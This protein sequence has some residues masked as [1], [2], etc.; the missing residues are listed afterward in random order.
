MKKKSFVIN[1]CITLVI[2]I[3]ATVVGWIFKKVGFTEPN[4]VII[5]IL[6]V[7]FTAR[8]T[9]GYVYGLGASVISILGFNYFFTAPYHTFNVYD[10]S[11]FVTFAIMAIT[12]VVTSTLTSKAKMYTQK[13]EEK[14]AQSRALYTLTNQLS[15]AE[16]TSKIME[17]G[18]RNICSLIQADAGFIYFNND[19]QVFI[20]QTGENQFH[21]ATEETA[22]LWN[23]LQ[24]LRAEHAE[25]NGY[26]D[27]PISGNDRLLGAIRL[28]RNIGQELDIERKRMLHSMIENI[29]IA[30]DRIVVMK[31]RMLDREAVV[32]E[33]YRA[34]LLRSI[35]HDLRT[36]LTGIIGTAEMVMD[37]TDSADRRYDMMRGIYQDADWLHSLV[38]NILSLTRLQDGKMEV[39]KEPEALEEV[40]ASAVSHTEKLHPEREIQV[41]LPKEFYLVPMDARLIQQVINNLLDNAIKHTSAEEK[42]SILVSYDKNMAKICVQDEGEGI[43]EKDEDN[44]FQMFYTT[45]TKSADAKKGVGLGLAIC[46]TV[47]KAHDGTIYGGNRSNARGAEFT[48]ELPLMKKDESEL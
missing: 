24:N 7:L 22:Q 45:Q 27:F 6:A 9:E 37:M 46:E 36:P 10:P 40:I 11:Y 33:R 3:L 26:V 15:D 48:F 47:V 34:N 18:L 21:R 39:K 12:S 38:E 14:E 32:R 2:I 30:L 41:M 1:M 19:E 35:S 31:E 44:I 29:A 23:M 28:E 20:Q 16:D 13:A 4:V 25:E 43:D 5:Y 17:I 42:I 8:L